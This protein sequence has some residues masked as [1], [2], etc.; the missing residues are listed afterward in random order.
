MDKETY[1]ASDIY[2]R[3]EVNAEGETGS[4]H[5]DIEDILASGDYQAFEDYFGDQD[6]FEF[7]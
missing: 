2:E 7:L 6:P 3:L 4:V 1:I 5:E